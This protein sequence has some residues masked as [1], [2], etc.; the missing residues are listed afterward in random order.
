ML[1]PYP[2]EIEIFDNF[3]GGQIEPGAP[4]APLHRIHSHD[5]LC[6]CGCMFDELEHH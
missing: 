3:L 5:E 4:I 2:K 1:C 6:L